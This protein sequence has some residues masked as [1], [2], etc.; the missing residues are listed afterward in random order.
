M[1]M[2]ANITPDHF[3]GYFIPCGSDKI[4]IIPQFSSPQMF[5]K[6]RE[7]FKHFSR[8]Y[9]FEQIYYLCRRISRRCR[10]KYM[11]M[12]RHYFYAIYLKFV[13]FSYLCKYFF[14]PVL[15]RFGKYFFTIF[16]NPNKMVFDII[17]CMS[18]P[19]NNH[20]YILAQG[21]RRLSSP[22]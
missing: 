3:R 22:S 16:R 14:Q 20:V 11:H 8:T 10:Q 5:E 15:L 12:F 4:T 17:Y 21:D 9:T 1:L 19:F 13:L 7:L 6:I 2:I 18:G